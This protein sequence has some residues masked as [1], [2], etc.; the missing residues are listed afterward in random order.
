MR[1]ASRGERLGLDPA[2]L[3]PTSKSWLK[4]GPLEGPPDIPEEV[5]GDVVDGVLVHPGHVQV[6]RAPVQD[7]VL[8]LHILRI[9]PHRGPGGVLL[10]QATAEP[11]GMARPQIHDIA[12]RHHER[13]AGLAVLQG[14][15]I[16][17][18]A[19][20]H[21]V[22]PVQTAPSEEVKGGGQAFAE[23]LGQGCPV[24]E[25]RNK[26]DGQ[27]HLRAIAGVEL[28]DRELPEPLDVPRTD[29]R[30]PVVSAHHGHP[31]RLLRPP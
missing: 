21:A 9:R 30:Y 6:E 29:P 7:E 23:A 13:V 11:L 16:L 5:V 19:V 25:A 22:R 2:I 26:Q 14:L 15:E 12:S 28:L 18:L 17:I 3:A 20:G 24:D 10:D 27:L 4:S 8:A 1:S 31:A